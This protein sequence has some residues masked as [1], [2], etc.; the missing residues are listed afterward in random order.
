MIDKIRK[1][2]LKQKGVEFTKKS[3]KSGS[4]Y[5]KIGDRIIRVS[6][7]I[8]TTMCRPEALHIIVTVNSES[9]IILV[10]NRIAIIPNYNKLKEYLKF[11]ILTVGV[12]GVTVYSVKEKI[13]ERVE[14]VTREVI[15]PIYKATEELDEDAKKLLKNYSRLCP[16]HKQSLRNQS[17]ELVMTK[18]SKAYRRKCY[19]K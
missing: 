13:V 16:Q 11:Y 1:F 6:D 5:F 18:A 2:L 10:N 7:H 12:M 8:P 17:E 9:F 14:E 4:L 19:L 15:V 3:E